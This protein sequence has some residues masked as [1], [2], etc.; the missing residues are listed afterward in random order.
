MPQQLCQNQIHYRYHKQRPEK[1]EGAGE[2]FV[3]AS[4]GKQDEEKPLYKL[5]QVIWMRDSALHV[6]V[7]LVEDTD[8]KHQVMDDE[9]EQCPLDKRQI[10]PF[11]ASLDIA[12]GVLEVGLLEEVAGSDEEYRH[13]EEVYEVGDDAVGFGV[14]DDHEDDG[15]AF[16]DSYAVVAL[17]HNGKVSNSRCK[18]RR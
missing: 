11:G 10:E 13:M 17:V 9:E 4:H 3:I 15:E 16:D 6:A 14:A 7:F 12:I 8:R 5:R 1:P 2:K 18:W